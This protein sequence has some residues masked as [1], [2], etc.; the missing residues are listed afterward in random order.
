MSAA[1]PAVSNSNKKTGWKKAGSAPALE[2]YEGDID[3]DGRA[4]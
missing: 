2:A 3:G 1:K 4:S